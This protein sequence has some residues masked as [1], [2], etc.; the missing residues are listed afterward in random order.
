[1]EIIGAG[2]GRTGTNSLKIAI[3]TL[4]FRPCY[5]MYEVTQNPS[6]INFWNKAASNAPV[7]WIDFF[8]SYKATVD[9]PASAFIPQIYNAF[10]S[11]KVIITVR[12]PEEWYQSAK[13][14]I[15]LTMANWEKN[16]NIETRDRM[17]MAKK[18]ILDGI[19]SGKHENKD[20]CIDV[21]NKHIDDVSKVVPKENLLVFDVSEGWVPLCEFLNVEVPNGVFPHTN[22]RANFLKHKP[23]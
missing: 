2:F 11:S 17:G 19:F 20:H 16:E 14:T 21:F 6:H 3:E 9:W 1:M 12:D 7:E 8:K 10:K 13:K 15:F 23:Q 4:G 5:H 22:T 18:I